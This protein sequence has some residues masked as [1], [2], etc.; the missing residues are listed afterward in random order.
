MKESVP[1]IGPATGVRHFITERYG[2]WISRYLNVSPSWCRHFQYLGRWWSFPQILRTWESGNDSFSFLR[3]L[4]EWEG[5]WGIRKN[6]V[7]ERKS[8]FGMDSESERQFAS[9]N[10]DFFRCSSLSKMKGFFSENNYELRPHPFPPL[11]TV[12]SNFS[13]CVSR[14]PIPFF[15][16]GKSWLEWLIPPPQ[17]FLREW[18]W[19]LEFTG[20]A[21]NA[22]IPWPFVNAIPQMTKGMTI[23]D[24]GFLTG[25]PT[26][27]FAWKRVKTQCLTLFRATKIC[28]VICETSL[29]YEMSYSFRSEIFVPM[30]F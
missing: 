24:L 29:L 8:F 1:K 7:R 28:V 4:R 25:A 19:E 13:H 5:K 11:T 12:T 22:T 20:N 30:E 10:H 15:L 6:F 14:S 3:I 26:M 17:R 18:E 23:A 27:K 21:N 2:D 9:K 16:A